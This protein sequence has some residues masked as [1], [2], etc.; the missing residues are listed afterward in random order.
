MARGLNH[1]LRLSLK[2][3]SNEETR[4]QSTV[5]QENLRRVGIELDL[6]SYEF[7]TFFGDVLQ[8]TSRCSR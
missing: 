1:G 5:V 8:G 3:S 7:A 2:I 4:L 6:R